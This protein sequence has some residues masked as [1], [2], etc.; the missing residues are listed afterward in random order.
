[1]LAESGSMMLSSVWCCLCCGS[2][3]SSCPSSSSFSSSSCSSS[4]SFSSSS[5]S[6]CS[7]PFLAPTC[8]SSASSS[9]SS[10]SSSCSS[11]SCSSSSLVF[12]SF[13]VSLVSSLSLSESVWLCWSLVSLLQAL[14]LLL[15][16]SVP[17]DDLVGL[18]LSDRTR[19]WSGSWEKKKLK[20]Y[21]NII[22]M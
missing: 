14:S 21:F 10:S 2:S 8:S 16:R 11:S 22:L 1:M 5:S 18:R 3:F 19:V 17:E 20:I 4:S 12:L 9:S 7:P 15:L 13:I 6:S